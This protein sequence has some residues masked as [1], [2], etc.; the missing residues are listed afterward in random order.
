MFGDLIMPATLA[1]LP[2]AE[3]KPGTAARLWVVSPSGC[4][5]TDNDVG[6]AHADALISFMAENNQPM[7]LGLVAGAIAKSGQQSGIE[8][9]F[10][11]R[12]AVRAIAGRA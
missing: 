1:T 5:S 3:A 2:F 9:G 11:H 4:W 12:L 6:G 7:L 10:F 8:C